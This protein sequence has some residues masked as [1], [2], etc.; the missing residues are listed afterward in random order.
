MDFHVLTESQVNFSKCLQKTADGYV[1]SL[2]E[3]VNVLE[4][5]TGIIH[6]LDL[7][8]ANYMPIIFKLLE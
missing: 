8:Y 2:V 4:L 1:T 3:Y 5:D 6:N 7:E